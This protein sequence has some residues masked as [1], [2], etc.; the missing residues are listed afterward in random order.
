MKSYKLPLILYVWG[1]F[2]VVFA[3]LVLV[4]D[5]FSIDVMMILLVV[6]GITF[7]LTNR[8]ACRVEIYDDRF[9]IRYFVFWNSSI[10]IFFKDIISVDYKKGFFDFKAYLD[11]TYSFKLICYDTLILVIDSKR[12]EIHIN[13][14]FGGFDGLRNYIQEK[15]HSRYN[16]RK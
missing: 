2:S 12:N 3:V 5:G 7:F 4:R 9:V 11:N 14:R 13:T 8:Y 10:D 6:I 15:L 1:L 16:K